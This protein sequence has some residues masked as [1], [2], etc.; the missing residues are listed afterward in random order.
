MAPA[1]ADPRR[2]A[3]TVR[4]VLLAG[5]PDRLAR[6]GR[7]RLGQHLPG[8][9][10]PAARRRGAAWAERRLGPLGRRHT[11]R[12]GRRRG[13]AGRPGSA[14][15][16]PGHR[17]GA[18]RRGRPLRPPPHR[19]DRA[20]PGRPGQERGVAGRPRAAGPA[21]ARPRR[22]GRRRGPGCG[23]AGRRPGAGAGAG[24]RPRTARGGPG[25]PHR[26]AA[27]GAGRAPRHGPPGR[28]V[29]VAGLRLADGDRAA[30]PAGGG[31]GRT[32]V[33]DAGVRPPHRRGFG[34]PAAHQDRPGNRLRPCARAPART[35]RP[36]ARA[37]RAGRARCPGG[38]GRR[39]VGGAAGRRTRRVRRRRRSRGRSRQRSGRR[40][41][42][43]PRG[44]APHHDSDGEAQ[45]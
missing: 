2:A 17:S 37:R 26:A 42:C 11:R 5:R 10:G 9:P 12:L 14:P 16:R 13:P 3:G 33:G 6:P 7:L 35:G 36:A 23:R 43:R 30:R 19:G 22:P 44:P 15:A 38:A 4:G 1:R 28:A 24:P 29:P 20:G 41:G 21:A 25:V 40:H 27:P 8:R 32:A 34:R 31:A 45:T 18:A 39:R